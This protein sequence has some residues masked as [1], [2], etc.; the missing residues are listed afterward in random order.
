MKV[1]PRL[2]ARIR[3]KLKSPAEMRAREVAR[4]QLR[5]PLAR[6]EAAGALDCLETVAATL[7]DALSGPSFDAFCQRGLTMHRAAVSKRSR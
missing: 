1:A 3:I 2:P 5:L 4:R 6:S 7:E